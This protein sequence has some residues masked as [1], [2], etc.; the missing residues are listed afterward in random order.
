MNGLAR[1]TRLKHGV[2]LVGHAAGKPR[3]TLVAPTPLAGLR[4]VISPTSISRTLN[5]DNGD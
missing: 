5:A 3:I 1:V 4:R 2:A